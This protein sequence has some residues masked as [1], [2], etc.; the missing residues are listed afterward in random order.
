MAT[1]NKLIEKMGDS[2]EVV[3]D[4]IG[5]GSDTETYTSIIDRGFFTVQRVV[6]GGQIEGSFFPYTINHPLPLDR[7]GIHFE[8]RAE[9]YKESCFVLAHCSS[10]MA[11]PETIETIKTMLKGTYVPHNKMRAI[12]ER[13]NL[14]VEVVGAHKNNTT[15]FKYGGDSPTIHLGL[16]A[17]HYFLNERTEVIHYTLEHVDELIHRTDLVAP[18]YHYRNSQKP[19]KLRGVNSVKLVRLLT[20]TPEM[21]AKW[22]T[23]IPLTYELMT[24]PH[25]RDV[26]DEVH[27]QEPKEDYDFEIPTDPKPKT[28]E[29]GG[30]TRRVFFDF[31]TTT[32]GD[33]HVPY[34]CSY[35]TEYAH[36][37]VTRTESGPGAVGQ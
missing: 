1:R 14:N 13:F 8:L 19:E 26:A 5:Q 29:D 22:L 37:N 16:I 15:H 33:K 4:V 24:T 20:K 32:C 30:I 17:K 18:W 3:D 10:G 2:V 23:D 35:I 7:Y 25:F 6:D 9:A 28:V 34:V 31:E 12:C 21:R 11:T 36:G 27:A